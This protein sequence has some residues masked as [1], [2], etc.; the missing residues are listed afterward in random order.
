MRRKRLEIRWITVVCRNDF[1]RT[2]DF[3]MDSIIGS[4]RH[5]SFR[6]SDFGFSSP[7]GHSTFKFHTYCDSGGA[8]MYRFTH[9]KNAGQ[10]GVT[11]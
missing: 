9:S 10:F 6:V 5:D 11:S 4:R 2:F 7:F 1:T 8:G 3:K